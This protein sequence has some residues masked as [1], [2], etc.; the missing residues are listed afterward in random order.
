MTRKRYIK[1]L[2]STGFWDRNSAKRWAK[3][4]RENPK[5][6]SCVKNVQKQKSLY[7][8]LW[9]YEVDCDDLL[10]IGFILAERFISLSDVDILEKAA[11]EIYKRNPYLEG[12]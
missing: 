11:F 4:W 9:S 5:Y 7:A 1:L 2:L 6:A 12:K 3:S 10:S 8:A